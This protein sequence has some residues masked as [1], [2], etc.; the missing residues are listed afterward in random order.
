MI[1]KID[2]NSGQPVYQQIVQQAKDA[3]GTGRLREGNRRPPIREV[4]VQLRVNRNTVARAYQELERE[5]VLRTGAGQGSIIREPGDSQVSRG[6]VRKRLAGLIDPML[7][8]A[9][10]LGM[11]EADLVDLIR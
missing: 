5:G 8:E 6:A 3:V 4:A 7:S 9:H 10:R 2:P 1:V 11:S